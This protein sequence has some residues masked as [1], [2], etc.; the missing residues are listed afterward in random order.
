[1]SGFVDAASVAKPEALTQDATLGLTHDDGTLA[2]HALL[3]VNRLRRALIEFDEQVGADDV[4]LSV[5]YHGD[6][7]LPERGDLALVDPEGD[8]AVVICGKYRDADVEDGDP[9]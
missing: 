3:D 1:M 8:R 6:G 7:E 9:A 4:S 2:E 5:I